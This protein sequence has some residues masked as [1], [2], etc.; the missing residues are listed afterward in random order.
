MVYYKIP[1]TV[2]LDYPA[3]CIL[4]C[5]YTYNGY[6]YCKFERVTEV[7]SNWVAI[8]ES[9][10][11]VRCPD[12]PEPEPPPAQ[13]IIATAAMMSGGSIV[14]ELPR[15]VDT[16]TLVKFAAP[17]A[18]SSLTGGI[19]IDGVTYAVVDTTGKSVK[20]ATGVW[21]NGAHVA[22][23]IDKSNKRA[24]FQGTTAL[25]N[26]LATSPLIL[27][28]GRDYGNSVPSNLAKG[29]IYWVKVVK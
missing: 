6:E 18:C 3:G 11:N 16:G 5:A 19:V 25:E 17:C 21:T 28:E 12:F 2:G 8:T 27:V 23:I 20:G 15:P 1:L 7:G 9:E 24:Y 29:Q 4:I 14:L 26:I 10:F 13:E 22:V